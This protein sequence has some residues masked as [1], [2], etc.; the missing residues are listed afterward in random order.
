[1][2]AELEAR[3][4]IVARQEVQDVKKNMDARV[5]ELERDLELESTGTDSPSNS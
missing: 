4:R 5:A 1:M 2:R 3:D